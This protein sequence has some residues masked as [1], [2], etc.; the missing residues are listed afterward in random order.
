VAITARVTPV[1]RNIP[2]AISAIHLSSVKAVIAKMATVAA[3]ANAVSTWLRIAR[4]IIA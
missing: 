3:A 4:S 1:N 2:T